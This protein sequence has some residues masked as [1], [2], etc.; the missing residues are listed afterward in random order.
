MH[1]QPLPIILLSQENTQH[2]WILPEA[3]GVQ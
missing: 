3:L 2:F 1:T